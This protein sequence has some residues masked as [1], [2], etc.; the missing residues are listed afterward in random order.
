M[1][2]LYA[3]DRIL[4]FPEL[5]RAALQYFEDW[6]LDFGGGLSVVKANLTEFTVDLVQAEITR[7]KVEAREAPSVPAPPR[8]V[9]PPQV[10]TEAGAGSGA[11][12][13]D[14]AEPVAEEEGPSRSLSI[15]ADTA[16]FDSA[17]SRLYFDS[18]V[19]QPSPP[20]SQSQ[21]EGEEEEEEVEEEEPESAA[22][23]QPQPQPLPN[24]LVMDSA[25]AEVRKQL[26]GLFLR[27]P[28]LKHIAPNKLKQVG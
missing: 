27:A 1:A 3:S 4:G 11:G 9:L 17:N 13:G 14:Q 22:S 12:A 26:L 21:E 15:V 5:R 2:L 19:K 25:A 8:P 16:S 24:K 7:R 23:P 28:K 18:E 6:A 10:P 20:Q